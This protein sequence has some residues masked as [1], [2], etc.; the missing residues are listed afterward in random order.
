MSFLC[1]GPSPCSYFYKVLVNPIVIL[2]LTAKGNVSQIADM[3][4]KNGMILER[5]G[6]MWSHIYTHEGLIYHNPHEGHVPPSGPSATAPARWSQPA[7]A[8][9]NVEVQRETADYVFQNLRGEED[10]PET[11]PGVTPNVAGSDLLLICAKA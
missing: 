1:Y 7:I 5:P 4:Y 10:L 8:A 3:L 9:K 2:V 11:S 6:S